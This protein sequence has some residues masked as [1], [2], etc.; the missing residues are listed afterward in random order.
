MKMKTSLLG[1]LLVLALGA[2]LESPY[3]ILNAKYTYT[4]DQPAMAQP[5]KVDQ[6]TDLPDLQEK[7][8]KTE[9]VDG[10]IVETYKEY[11][12]YKDKNG[13]ITKELPT[14][15][16]DTLQYWDYRNNND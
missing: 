9:R 1:L 2:Y 16:T 5:V 10:Y 8:E 7:L 11:E 14:G 15:K 3:S 12:V 13:N 6:P 4:A